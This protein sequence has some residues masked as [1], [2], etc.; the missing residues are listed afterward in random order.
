MSVEWFVSSGV[1]P[2]TTIGSGYSS[3]VVVKQGS[4][5]T[6][7]APGGHL[8]REENGSGGSGIGRSPVAYRMSQRP[9]RKPKETEIIAAATPAFEFVFELLNKRS[10]SPDR[11]IISSSSTDKSIALRI[12]AFLTATSTDSS[13]SRTRLLALRNVFT[14]SNGLCGTPGQNNRKVSSCCCSHWNL[15][16]HNSS[17][18]G[19]KALITESST[20]IGNLRKVPLIRSRSGVSTR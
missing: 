10:R 19:S 1:T 12:A 3:G 5:L 9:K 11:C 15:C 7:S 16:R 18:T 6:L 20:T 2:S 14:E 13:N 17:P 4:P 8:G